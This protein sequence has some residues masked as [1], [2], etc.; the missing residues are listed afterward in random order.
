MNHSSTDGIAIGYG[1]DNCGVGVPVLLGSRIFNFHYSIPSRLA[2]GP[3]YLISNGGGGS[4]G[5][6]FTIHFQLVPRSRKHESIH[7]FLLYVFIA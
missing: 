3:T 2:L 1:L 7:P 4:K 5:V 6:N